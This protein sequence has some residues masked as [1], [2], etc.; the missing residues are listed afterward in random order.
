MS[1]SKK[2]QNKMIKQHVKDWARERGLFSSENAVKQLVKLV[3]EVG[4][5]SG[6]VLKGR[7]ADQVDAIG[8]IQVVLIILSEQLGIDYDDALVQAYET[9]KHRTGKT[10]DGVFVKD[11]D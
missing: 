9:I 4:E 2:K 1:N 3:E 5:L 6:A 7:I 11:G 8:D 10:V